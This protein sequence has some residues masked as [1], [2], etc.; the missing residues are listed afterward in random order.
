MDHCNNEAADESK[1]SQSRAFASDLSLL[2][3]FNWA[4]LPKAAFMLAMHLH[5]ASSDLSQRSLIQKMADNPEVAACCASDQL[6][7]RG[8]RTV[9]SSR[10]WQLLS[11]IAKGH[12]LPVGG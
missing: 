12:L 5:L 8:L 6:L 11:E 7:Y 2:S 1:A 4:M 3:C 10:D 9:A